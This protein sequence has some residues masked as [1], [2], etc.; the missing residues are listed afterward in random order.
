MPR[1]LH[2]RLWL[3]AAFCFAA[4]VVS[5]VVLAQSA[6]VAFAYPYAV[7]FQLLWYGAGLGALALW[8]VIGVKRESQSAVGCGVWVALALASGFAVISSIP[9]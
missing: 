9:K 5:R 2:V 6:D 3:V 8:L 7:Q 1:W 4:G